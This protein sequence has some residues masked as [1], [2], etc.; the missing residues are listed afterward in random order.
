M[1]T[2]VAAT[3]VAAFACATAAR[4]ADLKVKPPAAVPGWMGPYVGV[5]AGYLGGG[6]ETTFPG[7]A[8][9]HFVDPQGF[10]GGVLAGYSMQRG[11]AVLGLE[12]DLA[13]TTAKES[14]DTGFPPDPTV[15]QLETRI[16][17]SSHVRGRVGYAFDRAMM[18]VAGGVAVAGVE[19]RAVDNAAG[20][21]AT[22]KDTRVGW[23]LGGGIDVLTAWSMLLRVEY[24]YDNYGTSTLPAQTVGPVTFP[25]R[26]HKLDSHTIRAAA[27]WRF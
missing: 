1:K 19:N 24:L 10:V 2:V 26:E 22:W 12:G 25:E 4:A 14:I 18:F 7:S 13:L 9:F 16:N 23:S 15:T 6:G 17:W 27:S 5:H 11:R 8:E 20:V 21:T 3:C